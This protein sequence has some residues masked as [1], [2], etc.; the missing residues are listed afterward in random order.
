MLWFIPL[1][2]SAVTSMMG[3]EE[4]KGPKPGKGTQGTALETRG[5]LVPSKGFQPGSVNPAAGMELP[6]GG[7][8]PSIM[9]SQLSSAT[10]SA[11]AMNA[12]QGA[13]TGAPLVKSSAGS[14]AAK[15]AMVGGG[16]GK[17][18]AAGGG[19]KKGSKGAKIGGQIASEVMNLLQ[20]NRGTGKENPASQPNPYLGRASFIDNILR[21]SFF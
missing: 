11:T 17:G 6:T 5:G 8:M 10:P 21:R 20:W 2:I 19:K 16:A 4:S 1:I 12:A 9:P 7:S 14:S 3:A 18:K 13:I 15:G